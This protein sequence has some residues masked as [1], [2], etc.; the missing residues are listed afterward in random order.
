MKIKQDIP[1]YKSD[2]LRNKWLTKKTSHY[3]FHYFQDSLAA[4]NIEDIIGLKEGHYDKI[5]SF[6][7]A[8]CNQTINYYIYPSFEEKI[9]LMGDDSP[10][11]VIWEEFELPLTKRFEIHIVYGDEC[12]F[13]GE[14][15]DTHL[16]SLPWGLSTYLFCEGLAQFMEGNLFG[17]DIDIASKELLN[18]NKLYSI[19]D[20]FDNKNWGKVKPEIIY[21]EVGSFT[22]FLIKTYGLNKF[23]EVYQRLSRLNNFEENLK[24]AELIFNKPITEIEADWREDLTRGLEN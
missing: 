1:W 6:L 3:I 18:E 16:L 12:K 10:G 9:S 13:V 20:L 7:G 21:P 19:K 15:E 17:K 24:I 5:L 14:H 22:R 4:I 2:Y 23:K 11:N 8:E